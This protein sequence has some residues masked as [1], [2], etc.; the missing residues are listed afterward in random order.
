MCLCGI[1]CWLLCCPPH[2]RP[3]FGLSVPV[4]LSFICLSVHC[5]HLYSRKKSSGK[6][7]IDMK[8]ASVTLNSWTSFE[9]RDQ[10]QLARV[11]TVKSSRSQGQHILTLQMHYNSWCAEDLVSMLTLLLLDHS[12][13]R[14]PKPWCHTWPHQ[15]IIWMPMI[16]GAVSINV[17]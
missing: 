16:G 3:H 17:V 15:R 1:D 13:R 9:V 10:V 8:V 6:P 11:W 14:I 4:C 5:L 7:K 2:S 12:G